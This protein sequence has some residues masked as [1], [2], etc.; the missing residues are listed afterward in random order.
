L[1]ERDGSTDT[2]PVS[3]G[4]VV[5]LGYQTGTTDQLRRGMRVVVSRPANEPADTIQVESLGG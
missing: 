3:D 2:I 1:R 4:T 5:R